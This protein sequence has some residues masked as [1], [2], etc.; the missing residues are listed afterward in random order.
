VLSGIFF[1]SAAS[2]DTTTYSYDPF[3]RLVQVSNTAGIGTTSS[4][5]YDPADNRSNVTVAT[6]PP[7]CSGVTFTIASNAAVTEGTASVF[8][9]T[10]TGTATGSCNVSYGT[11][12]GTALSTSDYTT[13][14]GT[15]TFTSAQTSQTVSV[16]TTS[17]TIA[18]TPTAETFTMSL[19]SPTGGA[20]LGTPN[21]ATATIND[22]DVAPTCSGVTFTIASNAAVT[23]GTAS[24]F[25]V[26][27]TGT[28]TGSCN[29][30]Y[31]TANGTATAPGDYTSTS[32]TLTFTSAQT[33]QTVSVPT[34]PD[35]VAETPTAETFAMSLSSPTGGATLGTP[36]SATATINDDDGNQP[37]VANFDN[38]GSMACNAFKTVNL[39]A[40]DT[41]PEGNL[42][43]ALVS[44]TRITG[45]I[46]VTK[47]STTS[48]QIES[49][50][51]GTKSFSYVVEDSLHAQ[52]TG[53]GSV[54]VTGSC[55]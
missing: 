13:T 11:A 22:D 6:A 49:L 40:N 29:V 26:T 17:D 18:E 28:A 21:S 39:V 2:S 3:G 19:S 33:S 24:V 31:A 32:G 10:K 50:T 7:T 12:N 52:S 48:I 27:K 5:V 8:T 20:T 1:A 43:L 53:S 46:I 30:S 41:D 42:P 23:E 54:T 14:T 38:A 35:T 45:G 34:T 37:P 16:P 15:L 47:V 4:Y 36:N 44:A 25:T 55:G 51:L 9:V